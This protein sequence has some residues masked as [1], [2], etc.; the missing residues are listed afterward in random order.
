MLGTQY[1]TIH[2]AI[3]TKFVAFCVN[4]VDFPPTAR[5]L[6]GTVSSMPSSLLKRDK[7]VKKGR[8]LL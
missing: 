8:K 5:H 6:F 7:S 1:R 2:D 3:C 4:I